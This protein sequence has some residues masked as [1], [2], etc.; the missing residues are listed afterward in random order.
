MTAVHRRDTPLTSSSLFV[1]FYKL[2]EAHF[3][4]AGYE[5]H[6]KSLVMHFGKTL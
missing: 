4:N 3:V 5:C 2:A 1:T 6:R